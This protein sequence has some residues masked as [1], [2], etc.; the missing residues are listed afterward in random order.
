[1][2]LKVGVERLTVVKECMVGE[3]YGIV[4]YCRYYTNCWLL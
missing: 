2:G 1:L 4:R 3:L